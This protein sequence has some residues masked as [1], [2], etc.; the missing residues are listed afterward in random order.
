M[1]A[2]AIKSEIQHKEER[3]H[4]LKGRIPLLQ[5]PAFQHYRE[6][7]RLWLDRVK[8]N[9]SHHR[10]DEYTQGYLH[11]MVECL[12]DDILDADEVAAKIKDLSDSIRDLRKA[13]SDRDDKSFR[14]PPPGGDFRGA[15]PG[16]PS[17]PSP[18]FPGGKL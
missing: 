1:K 8:G 10:M 14:S 9:L 18:T 3:M 2:A 15:P 17:T 7:K 6:E 4:A 5:T 12:E 11:G 16:V 13:L